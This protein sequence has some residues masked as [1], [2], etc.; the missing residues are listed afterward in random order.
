MSRY[1]DADRLIA[2]LKDEIE[3]C[4]PKCGGRPDI[5]YGVTLGLKSAIAFAEALSADVVEVRHA[6]IK[7]V[8]RPIS[9]EWLTVVDENG[10]SHYGKY[11]DKIDP[12]PVGYCGECGKRLD[13]TFMHFCPNCGARMDG[14][15]REQ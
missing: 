1:I 15:R 3:E 13:D 11:H 9:A 6:Q 2:H 12:N 8:N 7:W 14:E 10:D 5:A 4:D